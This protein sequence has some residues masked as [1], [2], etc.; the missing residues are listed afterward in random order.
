MI[1]ANPPSSALFVCLRTTIKPATGLWVLCHCLSTH[2]HTSNEKQIFAFF[3]GPFRFYRQPVPPQALE[4]MT[5]ILTLFRPF[6]YSLVE[7]VKL[8]SCTA[9]ALTRF[10]YKT[11]S[12][13]SNYYF[14]FLNPETKTCSRRQIVAP[15]VCLRQAR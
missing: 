13:R 2:T 15:I 4:C 8:I 12:G 3:A 5:T 9:R 14:F 6:A 11:C 10:A 1:A 7:N